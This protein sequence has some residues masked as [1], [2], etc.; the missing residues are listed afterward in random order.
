MVKE[1]GWWMHIGGNGNGFDKDSGDIRLPCME[2]VYVEVYDAKELKTGQM[3]GCLGNMAS[4]S[5][6]GDGAL[7]PFGCP[8]AWS[9][10]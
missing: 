1:N 5:G 4:V 2:N 7:A 3:K 10:K 6:W 9:T 8:Q